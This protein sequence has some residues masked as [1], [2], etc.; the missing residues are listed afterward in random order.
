MHTFPL[1]TNVRKNKTRFVGIVK[2]SLHIFSHLVNTVNNQGPSGDLKKLICFLTCKCPLASGKV[3]FF[4]LVLTCELKSEMRSMGADSDDLC[5]D[6]LRCLPNIPVFL[7]TWS[8][9]A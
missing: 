1:L 9:A 3:N 7:Q 5:N 2:V 6:L 8:Q 4:R